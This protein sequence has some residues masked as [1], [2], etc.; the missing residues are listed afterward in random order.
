MTYAMGIISYYMTNLGPQNLIGVK[1][2]FNILKAHI[3]SCAIMSW[4][5]PKFASDW[6]LQCK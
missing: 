5:L 2:V 4:K 3:K 1:Y 6:I